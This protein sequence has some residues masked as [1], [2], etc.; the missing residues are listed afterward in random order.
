MVCANRASNGGRRAT[1]AL[2]PTAGER[3]CTEGTGLIITIILCPTAIFYIRGM[4]LTPSRDIGIRK[5][6]RRCKYLQIG[7]PC[8]VEA[9]EGRGKDGR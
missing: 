2:R 8:A 3:G 9:G 6:I 4:K 5:P 1:E 7:R